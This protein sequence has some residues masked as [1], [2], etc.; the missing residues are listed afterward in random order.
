MGT[1]A[2]SEEAPAL[3]RLLVTFEGQCFI[4]KY[5]PLKHQ[6]LICRVVMPHT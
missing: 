6:Q 1:L 5:L 2:A 4:Q 3:P